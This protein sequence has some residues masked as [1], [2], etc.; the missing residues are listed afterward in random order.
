MAPDK[1]PAKPTTTAGEPSSAPRK[2]QRYFYGWNIVG[3]SFL[4]HLSYSEQ[5]TTIL[6]LFFRPFQQ[7]FGWSRTEVSFVQSLARTV[8]A[9]IGMLVGPLIDRYGPRLL[10]ATGAI[11]VGL[12]ML[13]ITQIDALWQ[14]YFLRGV[15]AAAGFTLMG[16]LVT[17][18]VI[19]KWFIRRRGRA[20]AASSTATYLSNVIFA[21]ITVWILAGSG[22]QSVFFVYAVVTW[23]LVLPAA[24]IMRRQP[25]DLGL[26][27]D[28]AEAPVTNPAEPAADAATL[29]PIWNRREV[30]ATS[31]FWLLVMGSSVANLAFQGINISLAPYMQDLGHSDTLVA[32]VLTVRAFAMALSLASWGFVAERAYRPWAR[33]LPF[34]FQALGSFLFL[35][36]EEPLF[37]WIAVLI[38][39]MGIAGAQIIQ[40]VVWANYYGRLSLGLVRSAAFP[41]AFGFSAGGPVFMNAIFDLTGSYSPAY[42]LFIGCFVVGAVLMWLVQPPKPRRYGTAADMG[43][44]GGV[45]PLHSL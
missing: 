31:A 25:E 24:F 23:A 33:A 28:G 44:P 26:L 38:Y 3:A 20:I 42:M 6:G 14:F 40:E 8:E 18:V 9:G 35:L 21:P 22:W 1:G 15:V 10:M 12:A 29:E 16:G 34:V 19:S 30:L 11:V 2:R 39:G 41:V 27:P 13:A 43:S 17:N 32:T 7:Q 4:A 36:A 5:Y 37:L 45:H